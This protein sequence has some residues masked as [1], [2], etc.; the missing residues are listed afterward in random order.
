MEIGVNSL[1][2]N[3]SLCHVSFFAAVM[4]DNIKDFTRVP[5]FKLYI[6]LEVK[7]QHLFNASDVRPVVNA[8]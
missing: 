8:I 4:M 2:M 1:A 3:T 7:N 5:Y 6:L